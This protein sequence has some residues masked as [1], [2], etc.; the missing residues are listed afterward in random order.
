MK[1]II[2]VCKS[3]APNNSVAAVRPTKIA[4]YLY[5]TGEY[6]ID[7]LKLHTHGGIEDELLKKDLSYIRRIYE[8]P[9]KSRQTKGYYAEKNDTLFSKIKRKSKSLIEH[10]AEWVNMRQNYIMAKKY[11]E[12]NLSDYNYD[13]ILSSSGPFLTHMIAR[14]LKRKCSN[15]IWIADY[16]DPVPNTLAHN[17]LIKYFARRDVRRVTKNVDAVLGATAGC[18]ENM[19]IYSK[20]KCFEIT[21]GYDIEDVQDIRSRKADKF[22][23][24]YTGTIHLQKSDVSI[25]FKALAELIEEGIIQKEEISVRYAGRMESEFVRQAEQ[26]CLGDSIES[27]GYVGRKKSLELQLGSH[28]LLLASFNYQHQNDV[29]TGKF[30]EYLMNR[31]PIVCTIMGN[32]SNSRLK[33]MIESINCGVCWEEANSQADYIKVKNYLKMQYNNYVKYR[34]VKYTIYESEMAKYDYRNI[35]K[36]IDKIIKELVILKNKEEK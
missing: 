5:K 19:G 33:R 24:S 11:V 20:E 31:R 21:N 26:F 10:T 30:Y 25:V 16:R 32:E 2:F 34:D 13:I 1:R 17:N 15:A 36:K 27:Y 22:T 23:L 8:V 14:Q 18:Y 9:Q 6:E 29:I 7:V 12:E 35:T 28:I 3:F 4:K